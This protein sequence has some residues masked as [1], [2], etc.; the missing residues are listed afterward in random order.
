MKVA[1]AT[2]FLSELSQ[3]FFLFLPSGIETLTSQPARIQQSAQDNKSADLEVARQPG[4]RI[5]KRLVPPQF[6]LQCLQRHQKFRSHGIAPDFLVPG[7]PRQA[8]LPDSTKQKRQARYAP[9][10]EQ[11]VNIC[12]AFVSLPLTKISG[13][14]GSQSAKPRNSPRF[15]GREVLL[16]TIPLTMTRN[17][18]SSNLRTKSRNASAQVR[19]V[20][21]A[22]RLKPT[23][24]RISAATV[25]GGR[26]KGGAANKI[27]RRFA[28]HAGKVTIPILPFLA[29]VDCVQQIWAG[30][31]DRM[32]R[33]SSKIRYGYNFLWRFREE[34]ITKRHMDR[35]CERFQ[36]L[37]CRLRLST[38]PVRQFFE[39]RQQVFLCNIGAF[40]RPTQ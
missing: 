32:P 40:T 38:L 37:E 17:P 39:L 21:R 25:S 35:F 22:M 36:L 10:R 5:R 12:A 20:L 19:Q 11:A 26:C 8:R 33:K 27:Q 14:N 18:V 23:M 31:R 1:A 3:A 24:S 6:G 7:S 15:S 4:K 16:N 2:V 9:I 34:Q 28:A 30:P 13:A 29:G